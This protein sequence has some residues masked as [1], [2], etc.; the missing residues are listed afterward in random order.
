MI[1]G[2]FVER[3][4]GSTVTN[5]VYLDQYKQRHFGHPFYIV[6]AATKEEWLADFT[7]DVDAESQIV[8]TYGYRY[9]YEVH[10][11]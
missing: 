10:T 6:R 5:V 4:I 2:S 3:E 8:E 1:V 7:T 9:F 11:D